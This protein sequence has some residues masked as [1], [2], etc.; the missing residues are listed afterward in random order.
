MREMHM[1]PADA[2][3]AHLDLQAR[4]SL[5]IHHRTFQ[6]TDEAINQPLLDLAEA[7]TKAAIVDDSF[8]SLLEGAGLSA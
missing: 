4:K 1:N 6:L 2:V 8:F 5:A 3:Q 7:L